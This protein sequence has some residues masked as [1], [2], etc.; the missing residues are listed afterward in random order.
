MIDLRSDVKT[1][2]TREMLEAMAQAELGDSKAG[3]DPT[4][5]RLE[6]MASERL[7][8][9]AAALMISGTMANL[10]ALMA[11]GEPGHG[12]VVDPDAHVYFYEGAHAKIAGLMPVLVPGENGL[13]DPDAL[14]QAARRFGGSAVLRVLC[15]ENTH[16]RA[17]GRAVP[18]S[19]HQRLCEVAHA[20]GMAVH[21]DGARIFN[22]SVATGTPVAE[23]ARHADSVMFCLSKSLCCPLGSV[24]CGRADFIARARRASRRLGGG[25]R[26][27]GVI[28]AAGIVALESM[29]DRLADDHANARLLAQGLED[30]PGLT[31]DMDTVETNM[32][33]AGV[34]TS[35]HSIADWIAAC[36]ARG[37]RIGAHRPDKLRFVT[38]RHHTPDLIRRAIDSTARA[39]A[40]LTP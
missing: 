19:L 24:L 40:D 12:M 14:D 32:V 9:E 18:V 25:M 38:H 4:V 5:L 39:A 15:L 16:N 26:Q 21:V 28:A 31:I 33:N 37:V 3:E 29:V 35:G 20:H 13:M 6:A 8:T 23:F 2:P 1:L 34:E 22:A 17:G 10:S 30:L 7:G 27:A 36:A 11:L